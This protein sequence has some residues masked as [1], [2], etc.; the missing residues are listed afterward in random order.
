M[1]NF[2]INPPNAPLVDK[3]GFCSTTWYRWFSRVDSVLGD[4]AVAA[5]VAAP[6]LTYSPTT[7][8]SDDKVIT[9]GS[10]INFTSGASTFTI[11]LTATGV[12]AASY[13]SASQVGTF[14]VDANGRL[15]AASNVT[16]TAAAIGAASSSLN[17]TAGNGLAGGGDLSSNRTFDVGA[18]TGIT[19]NANDVAL[20]TSSARNVDH[21]AV[22][23]TAG[24][25]LIGGG[26]L[27]ASRTF[28]VGAGTGITVNAND[29]AI[30]NT[31]VSAGSYGSATSVPSFTVNAQGQLTAASGNDIPTLTSGTY[32]PTLTNVANIDA[33]T[34]YELQYLRVGSTVTV[35]GKV[36]IDPTAAAATTQLGISLPVSSNFAAREDCGGVAFSN[37]I[38]TQGGAIRAD[39]TNDRAEMDFVSVGT[40]NSG[41]FFIFQYQII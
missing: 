31:A 18:G 6:V 20:D 33:S 36:D 14:T 4:D 16:I 39:F 24:S 29:V 12:T 38:G 8:F 34:A 35:S 25:G 3:G 9:A 15:T 27:E 37:T 21:A 32:T 40:A 10:G 23:F 7:A 1:P 26:T 22:T 13:G 11:A 19:V 28:D 41:M 5:L 30:S 17:L 2:K